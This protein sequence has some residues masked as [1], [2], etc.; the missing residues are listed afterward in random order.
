MKKQF[1]EKVK[2]WE[3][4][5]NPTGHRPKNSIQLINSNMYLINEEKKHSVRDIMLQGKL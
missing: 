1:F 2:V 4:V 5:T 3:W